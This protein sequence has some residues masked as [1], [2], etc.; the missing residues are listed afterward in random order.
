MTSAVIAVIARHARLD[1][2]SVI[3]VQDLEIYGMTG[4]TPPAC[5]RH[6]RRCVKNIRGNIGPI[7]QMPRDGFSDQGPELVFFHDRRDCA[8]F[9]RF[10][11]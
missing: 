6:S 1:D 2:A 9:G 11:V 8:P 3:R 5:K 10:G 4:V 7:A